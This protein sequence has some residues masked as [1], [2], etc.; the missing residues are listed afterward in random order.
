MLAL[1]FALAVEAWVRESR[2]PLFGV[3]G[4]AFGLT[5]LTRAMPLYFIPNRGQVEGLL[6]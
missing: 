1:S 3:A 2:G 4:A 6:F 5:A